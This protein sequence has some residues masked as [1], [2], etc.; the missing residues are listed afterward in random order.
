MSGPG[1]T[2]ERLVRS[3]NEPLQAPLKAALEVVGLT[4]K[5]PPHCKDPPP[6]PAHSLWPRDPRPDGSLA[7]VR[8]FSSAVHRAHV[9]FAKL[10]RFGSSLRRRRASA[11]GRYTAPQRGVEAKL[12][13]AGLRRDPGAGATAPPS[14]R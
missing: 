5:P 13:Q 3:S 9:A 4:D 7:A 11:R 6:F 10:L 8:S 14:T 1:R 12:G 2:H